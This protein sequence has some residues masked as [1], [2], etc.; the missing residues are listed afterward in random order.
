MSRIDVIG[1]GPAG[2]D[3][4]TAGSAAL[5]AEIPVRFVRTSRH[6]AAA[7]VEGNGFDDIYETADSFDDVYE[8]IVT[9][10][11]AAA[12]EAGRILYAVPGSPRVAE[13]TVDI[14]CARAADHGVEV[15]VHPALSFADLAW[16]ALGVDPVAVGARIVDGL[17]FGAVAATATGPLLVAQC[18]SRAVLSDIKLAVDGVDDMT[19]TVLARLG[20]EDQAVFEL[21]WS[22]IDRGFEPD[23]LTSLYIPALPVGVG[24]AFERFDGLVRELRVGCP[25]DG[26]QTHAS[27]RRYLLEESYET[28]EALDDLTAAIQACDAGALGAAKPP[29]EWLHDA[30]AE[31]AEELGDLLYQ[32]FFHALLA[33]EAGWFDV[34]A[35]ATGIHDKLVERHP[36]V[37]GDVETTLDELPAQWEQSKR[38]AKGR[39]SVMDGIPK[40]L[41][42]LIY[43]TKVQKKAAAI[44]Q[45]VPQF[46]GS[47]RTEQALAEML[48]E[49][50]SFALELDLDAESVLRERADRFA[51]QVRANERSGAC[52]D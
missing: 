52:G 35:V 20:T 44:G 40:A 49:A 48:F 39:E 13:R 25:W 50:V 41:P 12:A 31:V 45:A 36:H 10:L 37:F 28:L 51:A 9:Q 22:E 15:V 7:A 17:E 2:A 34:G 32:I 18:H 27:L 24:A 43:A 14:L 19:V 30:Y 38:D 29:E 1:L 16:V 42:A 3:L 23:H 47:I 33:D 46:D 21:P 8:R 5:I 11:L 4:I 6:L 26:E